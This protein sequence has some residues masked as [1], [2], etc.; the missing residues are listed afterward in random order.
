M[1]S[2]S[3]ARNYGYACW[4]SLGVLFALILPLDPKILG[5]SLILGPMVKMFSAQLDSTYRSPLVGPCL[6]NCHAWIL[7]WKLFGSSISWQWLELCMGN[8][9]Y[10][11]PL[12][13]PMMLC[14]QYVCLVEWLWF[15]LWK[16]FYYPLIHNSWNTNVYNSGGFM[17]FTLG[18]CGRQEEQEQLNR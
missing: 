1:V 18:Q 16:V 3:F 11:C 6:G 7:S 12:V 15:F 5:S 10:C 4:G 13:A 9:S 14:L 8:D 17:Y 2:L